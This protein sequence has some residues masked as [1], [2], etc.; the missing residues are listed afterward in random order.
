M[1][2]YKEKNTLAIICFRGEESASMISPR[3]QPLQIPGLGTSVGTPEEG[4]TAQIIAVE[5]FEELESVADQVRCEI[6]ILLI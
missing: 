4:I 2:H 1:Y 5:S 6:I 3:V